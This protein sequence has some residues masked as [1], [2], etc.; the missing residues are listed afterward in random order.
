MP[1]EL[2]DAASFEEN[3]AAFG[4]EL[5]RLDP[6]LGPVLLLNINDL[7]SST[8]RADVLDAL[9]DALNESEAE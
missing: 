4:E 5:K 2:D 6:K 7:A 9:L 8:T 1:Y 3:L